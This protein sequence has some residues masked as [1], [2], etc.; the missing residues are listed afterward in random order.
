M[1][2]KIAYL[3]IDDAPSATFESKVAFL[4]ARGIPAVLFCEGRYLEA[5]PQQAIT[6]IQQGFILGNH[7]YNHPH[8]SDLSL[9]ECQDQIARTDALLE[10]LYQASGVAR[11]A[12]FFRFPYGDKGGLKYSEVLEPYTG[13]GARRKASLQ[14]FLCSL[15][16]SQPAFKAVTYPHIRAAGLLDDIDWYW[17]Y[18]VMEWSINA[19]EHEYGIDSL[20]KVFER[21]DENVPVSGRGLNDFTSAEIMLI[22]D[23]DDTAGCFEPILNRLLAKG[24]VFV[25]PLA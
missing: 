8:F 24:I 25:N 9:L 6:A 23:H 20:E 12:S 5:R 21:M 22:H 19:S 4:Q 11:P 14:A 10:H 2:P 17:T 13:E 15:G 3:T 7:A 16:Y 1:F 18:D